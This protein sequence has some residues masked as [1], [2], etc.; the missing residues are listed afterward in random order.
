MYGRHTSQG[1]SL[2]QETEKGYDAT[3][4]DKVIHEGHIAKLPFRQLFRILCFFDRVNRDSIRNSFN[5][6]R[7]CPCNQNSE[8]PE[9]I[10]NND[11]TKEI[12]HT[13]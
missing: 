12:R 2:A 5:Q 11:T 7:I 3:H 8:T 6:T 10:R 4:R 13:I 9:I 1:S